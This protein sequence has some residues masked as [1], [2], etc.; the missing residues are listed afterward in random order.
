MSLL[1]SLSFVRAISRHRSRWA[2][3][4]GLT[5]PDVATDMGFGAHSFHHV[6]VVQFERRALGADPGQF[7]E[8]VPRRWA[9]GGPLQRVAVAPWVVDGDN[10]AVAPA[11]EDVPHER[12]HRR[13]Q[14]EGPDRRDDVEALEA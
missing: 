9:A 10:L 6:R 12:E 13:A 2:D 11:L 4:F 5:V 7:G 3:G 1:S 14:D 8:V